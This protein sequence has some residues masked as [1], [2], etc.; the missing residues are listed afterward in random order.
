MRHPGDGSVKSIGGSIFK[1]NTGKG[2]IVD[3]G[4][5][6]TYLPSAALGS[7]RTLFQ[8]ISGMQHSN[9]VV[10]MSPAQVA[11]LPTIVY[12]LEGL[13]EGSTIDIEVPPSSYVEA[14]KGGR[15]ASRVYLTEASGAVLGANFMNGHNVVFDI[16]QLRV[17]FVQSDCVYKA[18][19]HVTASST[20]MKS[21][22]SAIA[23]SNSTVLNK[24]ANLAQLRA[25]LRL[26]DVD[27]LLPH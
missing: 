10:E 18:V 20:T 13:T 4:T 27:S 23:G 21:F 26:Q 3:S 12:R 11:R 16:E 8:S 9:N 22:G 15:Y 25:S 7:F 6:D 1:F 19:N 5:T 24:I 17:G 14:F 2:T